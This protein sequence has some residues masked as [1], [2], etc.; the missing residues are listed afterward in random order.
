[1]AIIG[2]GT[3]IEMFALPGDDSGS[4]VLFP[5]AGGALTIPFGNTAKTTHLL[6]GSPGVDQPELA[7]GKRLIS[8]VIGGV[9]AGT[10]DLEGLTGLAASASSAVSVTIDD[11]TG[12]ISGTNAASFRVFPN[13]VDGVFYFAGVTPGA[14]PKIVLGAAK[15]V[16]TESVRVVTGAT[17]F[18]RIAEVNGFQGPSFSKEEVD[19]TTLD[20]VGGFREFITTLKDAG[21]A[22]MEMNFTRDSYGLMSRLYKLAGTA[23]LRNWALT[24]NDD[25]SGAQ[26]TNRFCLW[27]RSSVLSLPMNIPLADKITQT[28]TL[29][30]TG[31]PLNG[32]VPD[33]YLGTGPQR[34]QGS[35]GDP[36]YAAADV[37]GQ[38]KNTDGS[39]G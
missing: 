8:A 13:Q 34:K 10:V 5:V 27:F 1:M 32:F 14:S 24:L 11:N 4:K 7:N 31:E 33:V 36:T 37:P 38:A 16:G 19:I 39:F 17:G 29:R 12:A 28:A 21:Q 20:S 15:V 23:G 2:I 35:P 22:T 9:N 6:G 26:G 3:F 25:P 18:V 30:L